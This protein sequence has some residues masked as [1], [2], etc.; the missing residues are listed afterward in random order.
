MRK[1]SQKLLDMALR[2]IESAIDNNEEVEITLAKE[3][4]GGKEE[5]QEISDKYET[6]KLTEII[7]ARFPSYLIG[8]EICRKLNFMSV[9]SFKNKPCEVIASYSLIWKLSLQR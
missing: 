5:A 3:F 9:R 4:V 1:K 2:E 8:S 7:R 6:K